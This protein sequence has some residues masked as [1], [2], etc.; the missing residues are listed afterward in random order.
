MRAVG[1]ICFGARADD[2]AAAARRRHAAETGALLAAIRAMRAH[3]GSRGVQAHGCRL[4]ATLAAG[5]EALEER[6]KAEGAL[7]AAVAAEQ[8]HPRDD[9]VRLVAGRLTRLFG[10]F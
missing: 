4:L 10:G 2:A 8:A 5:D 7:Q 1:L 3:P 9:E 6:A